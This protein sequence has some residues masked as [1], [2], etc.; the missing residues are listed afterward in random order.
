MSSLQDSLSRFTEKGAEVIAVSPQL[1]EYTEKTVDKTDAKFTMI[2]D[3][4]YSVSK[5]FDVLFKP[6]NEILKK[7]KR[8]GV[9][10]TKSNGNIDELLPVPAT[11]VI[12][13]D[14]VIKYRYFEH[15]YKQRGS[16]SEI[17]KHL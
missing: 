13:L 5:A 3:H 10:L 4:H 6:S 8:Y 2:Y 1:P 17:F 11:F 14:G 16:I 9:D 12:G 7:Y 15:D